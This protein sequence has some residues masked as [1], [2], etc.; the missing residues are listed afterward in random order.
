MPELSY[1]KGLDELKALFARLP[2]D[3]RTK[4]I[5]RGVSRAASEVKKAAAAA[6]PQ[7]SR[8]IPRGK[9]RPATQPGTLKRAA[10]IKLLRELSGEDQ[11]AYGVTFRQGRKAQ[12]KGRDAFYASWVER[13]HKIVPRSAKVRTLQ[14]KR[15]SAVALAKRRAGAS[16]FVPG[17]FFLA[18]SFGATR[19]RAIEVMVR[20]FDRGLQK[21]F[22]SSKA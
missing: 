4:V 20:E 11:I 18:Q 22:S 9:S 3:V 7:A 1:V 12:A 10:I 14:G 6:A 21:L 8:P 16:G 2:V 17:R 13:G 15:R 19:A 5:R